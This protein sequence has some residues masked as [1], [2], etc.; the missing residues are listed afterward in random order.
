MWGTEGISHALC[1]G[2]KIGFVSMT[3]KGEGRG[4]VTAVGLAM[5]YLF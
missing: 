5:V 4:F 1:A 2:G 3:R